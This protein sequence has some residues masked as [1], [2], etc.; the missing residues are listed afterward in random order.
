MCDPCEEGDDYAEGYPVGEEVERR[1]GRDGM[2][3][4]PCS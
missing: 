4:G 2:K 3:S 1:V